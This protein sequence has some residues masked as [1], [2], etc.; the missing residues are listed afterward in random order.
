MILPRRRWCGSLLN[1]YLS[2]EL[3]RC[4]LPSKGHGGIPN[5]DPACNGGGVTTNGGMGLA[6]IAC[7]P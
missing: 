7:G 1:P 4:G 6:P 5:P 3:D 2:T